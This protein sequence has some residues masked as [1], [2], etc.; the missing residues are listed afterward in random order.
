[1]TIFSD[2]K[3]DATFRGVKMIPKKPVIPSKNVG[4]YA[5]G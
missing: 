5:I 2:I 4:N 1:M 3:L